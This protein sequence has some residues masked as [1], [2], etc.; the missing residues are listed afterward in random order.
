M[1][2]SGP[3]ARPPL[4]SL[5]HCILVIIPIEVIIGTITPIS[6]EFTIISGETSPFIGQI[7]VQISLGK[8]SYQYNVFIANIS[9]EGIIGMDFLAVNQLFQY[10]SPLLK[11]C[12][13]ILLY[14][15]N[16]INELTPLLSITCFHLSEHQS[17]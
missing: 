5:V 4:V 15:H 13:M 6:I 2:D 16:E 12:I 10:L 11:F 1:P 14:W 17:Y 9:N 8:K 3:R 7:N